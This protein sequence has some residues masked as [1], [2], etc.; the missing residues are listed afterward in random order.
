MGVTTTIK[1]KGDA[2]Y[3]DPQEASSLCLEATQKH[4]IESC[5]LNSGSDLEVEGAN[6]YTEHD[7]RETIHALLKSYSTLES[8]EVF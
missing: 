3:F 8:T 5:E 4:S 7:V 1:L 2:S 6:G